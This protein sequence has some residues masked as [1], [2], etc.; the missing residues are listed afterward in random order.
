MQRVQKDLESLK[1]KLSE[2]EYLMRRSEKI[3]ALEKELEWYKEECIVQQKKIAL[4][5]EE[6]GRMKQTAE[7]SR[8]QM[9]E[10]EQALAKS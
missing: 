7:L 5:K 3:A 4:M 1:K 9:I 10:L 2:Q 6:Y 8:M